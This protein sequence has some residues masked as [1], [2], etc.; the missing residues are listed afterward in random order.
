MRAGESERLSE[1]VA[2]GV[3]MATV[4]RDVV[5]AVIETLDG[6]SSATGLPPVHF[7]VYDVHAMTGL[8]SSGHERTCAA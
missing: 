5:D 2:L 3:V 1:R 8:S 6:A 4:P 7:V